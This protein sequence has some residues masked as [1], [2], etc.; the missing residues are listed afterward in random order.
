MIDSSLCEGLALLMKH[1]GF[2]GQPYQDTRGHWTIGYGRNLDATP[3]TEGEATYL[4]E[5][6]V[7]RL[8]VGLGFYPW[9]PKLNPVRKWVCLNMAYHLGLNGFGTFKKMI[10]QIE[11]AINQTHPLGYPV[12]MEGEKSPTHI[13]HWVFAR[14]EMLNSKWAREFPSR[15]NEL[16][17]LMVRGAWG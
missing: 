8:D 7:M 11:I 5:N 15:A 9:Y 16:A 2:R 1:E 17:D 4:L 12:I 10:G 6:V 14:N 3:L 13:N